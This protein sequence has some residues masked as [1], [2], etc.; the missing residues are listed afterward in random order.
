MVPGAKATA[1]V[2]GPA[3]QPAH[4]LVGMPRVRKLFVCGGQ[5]EPPLLS[6]RVN[7]PRLEFVLK[8]SYENLMEEGGRAVTVRL[9]RGM[10]LFAAPNCWNLPTWRRRVRL[11]SVLFGKRQ[12]GISLVTGTG[13]ACPRLSARKFSLPRPMTGPLPKVLDAMLELQES[14]GPAAPLPELARTLLYC[15]RESIHQ[16]SVSEA[17]PAKSLLESVCSYLRDHYQLDITRKSVARQFGVSPNYLSRVFQGQ[18]RMTFSGYLSQLRID[19][20]KHLLRAYPLKLDDI[21][22]RCGY[23]DTAYFCRV[24]RHQAGVTAADYRAA[25]RRVG[26][27]KIP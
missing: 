21:A 7:F 22:A 25:H 19:H 4:G 5:L 18:A 6:H 26:V 20:A 15:L 24:F 8:G 27:T 17:G 2:Y 10:A 9:S 23:H 11:L 14:G 13:A 12:I 3:P 16:A 1:G